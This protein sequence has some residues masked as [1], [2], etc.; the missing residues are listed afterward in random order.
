MILAAGGAVFAPMSSEGRCYGL[1]SFHGHLLPHHRED[2]CGEGVLRGRLSEHGTLHRQRE[3]I[4]GLV[5]FLM[6]IFHIRFYSP[7]NKKHISIHYHNFI[8]A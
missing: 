1:A 4:E 2:G 8:G 3:V 7:E 5:P 6:K